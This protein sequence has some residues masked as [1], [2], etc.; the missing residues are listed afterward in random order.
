MSRFKKLSHV[1]WHCE[2]HIVWTPKYR[3]KVLKGAV[4]R[5]VRD[6]INGFASR[7]GCEIVELN[8]QVDHV[9]LLIRVPPKLSTVFVN[10]DVTSSC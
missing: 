9:H 4:S 10:I 6:S 3:Y 7:L 1:I 2:Y 5:E 8:I